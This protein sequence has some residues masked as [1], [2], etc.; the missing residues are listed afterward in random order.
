MRAGSCAGNVTLPGDQPKRFTGKER[1]GETGLDYFGARYYGSKPGRFTT[2]DPVYTWKE[3]LVDPQRWNRYAYSRNNP[4]RYVDPD[5][6]E[7]EL[8]GSDSFK[9]AY[10]TAKASLSSHNAAL[11]REIESKEA[12]K[13]VLRESM[14]FDV[15]ANVTEV[16]SSSP[17]VHWNPR[18]GLITTEGGG[19][20]PALQLLHELAHALRALK[21]PAGFHRDVQTDPKNLFDSPEEERVIRTIEAP[22]ARRRGEAERSDHKGQLLPVRD[23]TEAP[24]SKEG[25]K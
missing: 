7:V 19:Q 12:G 20:S 2:V 17:F 10:Q 24:K 25:S 23:V 14:T 16:I 13:V 5:G 6:R 18:A 15:N 9:M 3:N 11:I 8:S 22:A 4:L 21:D 1:D